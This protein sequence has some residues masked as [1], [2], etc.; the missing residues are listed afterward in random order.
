ML[1]PE[2]VE[3]PGRGPGASVS[4]RDWHANPLL[5]QNRP[6]LQL[7]HWS[8]DWDNSMGGMYRR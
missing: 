6:E 8:V 7:M 1:Y 3:G 2:V 5:L 4:E